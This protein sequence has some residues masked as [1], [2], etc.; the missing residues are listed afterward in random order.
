MEET[1]RALNCR[2]RE[3]DCENHT[4]WTYVLVLTDFPF[5]LI[6]GEGERLKRRWVNEWSVQRGREGRKQEVPRRNNGP[7]KEERRRWRG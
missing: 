4:R 1:R 6:K 5:G 2:Q 7:M 3:A